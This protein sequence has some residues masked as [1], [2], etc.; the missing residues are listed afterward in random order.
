MQGMNISCSILLLLVIVVIVAYGIY[1]DNKKRKYEREVIRRNIPYDIRYPTLV[2]LYEILADFSSLHNIKPFLIDGTLLGKHR[3]D[4]IITQDYDVDIGILKEDFDVL[5]NNIGEYI[6][7]LENIQ[8]IYFPKKKLQIMET[9]TG[10]TMDI[11][12]FGISNDHKTIKRIKYP[13]WYAYIFT[14]QCMNNFPIDWVLPLKPTTFLGKPVY[15]PNQTDVFLKC[16]Y[17]ED[18][19][20]PDFHCDQDGNNCVKNKKYEHLM[21]NL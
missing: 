6:Q 16:F 8:V 2:Y 18:Y 3:E 13:N 15:I 1:I 10:L 21:Q 4:D 7:D 20:T 14:N 12:V 5:Y 11:F 19:M 9:I 17:G